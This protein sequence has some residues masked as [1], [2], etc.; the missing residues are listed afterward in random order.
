MVELT[1]PTITE[2]YRLYLFLPFLPPPIFQCYGAYYPIILNRCFAERPV[3][4]A[5]C[6]YLR[7]KIIKKCACGSQGGMYGQEQYIF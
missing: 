5:F 2:N 3:Y 6:L 7:Y 4:R 1:P